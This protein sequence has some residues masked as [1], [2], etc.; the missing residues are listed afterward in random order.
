MELSKA[1]EKDYSPNS[2]SP[3]HSPNEHEVAPE[4]FDLEDLTDGNALTKHL[5]RA[6]STPGALERLET[7]SRVISSRRFSV[8][9]G[10]PGTLEIDP[11]DFD[12]NI[13]LKTLRARLDE[14]GMI[15]KQ[16]GVAWKDL[17]ANGIDA[18]TAYGPSVAEVF[19]GI[20]GMP[21]KLFGKEKRPIRRIIRNTHGIVRGGEMLLVLGRPGS[22]CSSLLKSLAGETSQ[23]TSVEGDVSYDGA[24]MA[25]MKKYFKSEVIYNPERK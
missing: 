20:L 8:V 1:K 25:D 19:H 9:S 13:L 22:G 2:L 16:C 21:K 12:L 11:D 17:T 18:S 10:G 23:F 6:M 4:P 3:N 7:F 24:S 15:V 5:S 14:K